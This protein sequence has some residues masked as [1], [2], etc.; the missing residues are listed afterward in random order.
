MYCVFN[1]LNFYEIFKILRCVKKKRLPMKTVLILSS[2]FFI[3]CQVV[4]YHLHI[5]NKLLIRVFYLKQQ[6]LHLL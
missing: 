2:F 5:S 3:L 1:T 6:S 4:F